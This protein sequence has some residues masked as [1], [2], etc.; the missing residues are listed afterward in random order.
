[1]YWLFW[2]LNFWSPL[3]LLLST[4]Y[5]ISCIILTSRFTTNWETYKMADAKLSK[6]GSCPAQIEDS[7]CCRS[8]PIISANIEG[9]LWS[10]GSSGSELQHLRNDWDYTGYIT[11]PSH[12]RVVC[13]Y[14]FFSFYVTKG[15]CSLKSCC[16]TGSL[17]ALWWKWHSGRRN[18]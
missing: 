3:F 14:S 4:K 1:M 2:F 10:T 15:V 17:R 6:Y 9:H 18:L 7:R 12:D 11:A 5:I 16:L 8:S 13:E